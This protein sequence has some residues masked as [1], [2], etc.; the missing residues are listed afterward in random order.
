M[1]A[2]GGVAAAVIVFLGIV[3]VVFKRRKTFSPD[4]GRK[5]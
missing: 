2:R 4:V 3:L 5:A 1:L